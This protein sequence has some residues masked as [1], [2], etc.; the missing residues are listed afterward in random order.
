MIVSRDVKIVKS[1]PKHI[2]TLLPTN[3]KTELVLPIEENKEVIKPMGDKLVSSCTRSQ[4][5]VEA[6][7]V[8]LLYAEATLQSYK[9]ALESNNANDW[10]MAI[11]TEMASLMKNDTWTLVQ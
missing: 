10:R 6:N 4:T 3:K 8:I 5:R 7:M 9:E 11:D 2:A 1:E